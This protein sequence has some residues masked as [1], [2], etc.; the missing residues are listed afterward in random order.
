LVRAIERLIQLDE[1][2]TVKQRERV[3]FLTLIAA[4]IEAL[5]DALVVADT[6]GTIVLI[7]EQTEFIFGYHRSQLIGQ[8]LELLLPERLRRGH[9]D[10]RR[11]YNQYNLSPR[12]RTMGIGTRLPALR[13]DGHEFPA[14]IILARL[15]VPKGVYNLAVVKYSP[16]HHFE[17]RHLPALASEAKT[18]SELPDSG[19]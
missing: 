19:Q 13:C 16:S 15:V 14:D 7:N 9:V 18:P 2:D 4:V 8:P 6:E 17:P 10:L 1:Q 3:S 12:A 5:P 11:N